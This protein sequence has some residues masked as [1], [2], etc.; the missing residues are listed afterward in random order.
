MNGNG[1]PLDDILAMVVF[2]IVDPR[3]SRKRGTLGKAEPKRAMLRR[4]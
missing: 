4:P 1:D 2:G 3:L